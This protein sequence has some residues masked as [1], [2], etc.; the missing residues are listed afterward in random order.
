[1]ERSARLRVERRRRS[2]CYSPGLPVA[3]AIHGADGSFPSPHAPVDIA[4]S[5]QIEVSNIAA[6]VNEQVQ[7]YR[8]ED[9]TNGMLAA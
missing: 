3:I 9:A 8:A 2:G 7:V 6:S 1:V 4:G 5:S